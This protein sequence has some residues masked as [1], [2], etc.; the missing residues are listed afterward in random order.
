MRPK[1]KIKALMEIIKMAYYKKVIENG[2]ADR[3]SKIFN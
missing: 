1:S 3:G 2:G